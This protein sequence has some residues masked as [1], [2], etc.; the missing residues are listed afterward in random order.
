MTEWQSDIRRESKANLKVI[1]ENLNI[2]SIGSS[3]RRPTLE[4]RND[5]TPSSSIPTED[6]TS[7]TDDLRSYERSSPRSFVSPHS[8]SALRSGIQPLPTPAID[9]MP[10]EFP[11]RDKTTSHSTYSSPLTPT[12]SFSQQNTLGSLVLPKRNNRLPTDNSSSSRIATEYKIRRSGS[13]S[14][15]DGA[16]STAPR[17]VSLEV[18]RSARG[19]NQSMLRREAGHK[20]KIELDDTD[21]NLLDSGPFEKIEI[22]DHSARIYRSLLPDRK[23]GTWLILNKAGAGAFSTVYVGHRL[24]DEAETPEMV[25]VKYVHYSSAAGGSPD[26]VQV[27][28]E[29]EVECLKAVQHPCLTSLLACDLN[30]DFAVLI[31]PFCSGGNMFDLVSSHAQILSAALVKRIFAEISSAVFHLHNHHFV[32][33]DL[34][35][36]SKLL[37]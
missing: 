22:D 10:I 7:S 12:V 35:L 34:K 26:R 1:T 31:M 29:R 16:V 18:S 20:L 24:E 2:N 33:R 3:N 23:D 32:H 28:V 25:A 14:N 21:Y 4:S 30:H 8:L 17:N 19:Y 6:S 37:K 9:Q 13:S 11:A 27:S 15:E 5:V 36:E